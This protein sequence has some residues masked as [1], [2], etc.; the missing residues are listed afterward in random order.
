MANSAQTGPVVVFVNNQTST[1]NVSFSYKVTLIFRFCSLRTEVN[2][3]FFHLFFLERL[4]LETE[5]TP[6]YEIPLGWELLVRQY[7]CPLIFIF[8]PLSVKLEK[9]YF[10]KQNFTEL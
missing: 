3:R 9:I 10:W 7:F 2:E 5:V 1:K 4:L 8:F 6:K